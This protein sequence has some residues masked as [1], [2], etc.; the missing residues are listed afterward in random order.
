MFFK[1]L[2]YNGYLLEP[3]VEIWFFFI[4][5]FEIWRIVVTYFQK[6]PLL[7]LLG[8]FFFAKWRKFATI[9]STGLDSPAFIMVPRA[10]SKACEH[11]P[12]AGT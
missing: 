5:S 10:K 12:T 7:M 6:N 3:K 4:L 9:K 8:H 2:L 11:V 1:I